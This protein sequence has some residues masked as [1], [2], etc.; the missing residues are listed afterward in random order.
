ML[1]LFSISWSFK[2]RGRGA[3][4]IKLICTSFGISPITLKISSA[5]MPSTSQSISFNLEMSSAVRFS[6]GV[7]V[8]SIDWSCSDVISGINFSVTL[9]SKKS[10]T[11]VY[12]LSARVTC[13][14]RNSTRTRV[15]IV[16]KRESPSFKNPLTYPKAIQIR[17]I[18]PTMIKSQL[19]IISPISSD[20]LPVIHLRSSHSICSIPKLWKSPAPL[21]LC[22][23]QILRFRLR[24]R[25]ST[26]F[27]HT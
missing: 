25:Y 4:S 27:L 26:Y 1:L 2:N 12:S 3:S 7:P 19:S 16:D 18:V 20:K 5:V 21:F 14:E 23:L 22:L 15:N 8:R 6:N 13:G 17:K 24:S 11:G 9:L 10:S